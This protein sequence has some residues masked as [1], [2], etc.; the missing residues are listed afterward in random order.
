MDILVSSILL[1]FI[2]LLIY[3]GI[4]ATKHPK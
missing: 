4:D 2:G 1:A 3:A